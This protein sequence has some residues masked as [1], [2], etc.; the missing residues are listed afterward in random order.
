MTTIITRAGKGSA[1]TN[2]E[3]DQNFTNLNNDKPDFESGTWTPTLED[4]GNS[5]ATS[6]TAVS[7]RYVKVGSKVTVFGAF[8]PDVSLDTAGDY[9]Y[10]GGL[11]FAAKSVGGSVSNNCGTGRNGA[12]TTSLG[13]RHNFFNVGIFESASYCMIECTY[14]AAGTQL[15]SSEINFTIS[16]ETDA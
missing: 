5:G 8:A 4:A 14:V 10:I 7:S 3:G 9:I 16:Y 11:P 13:G 15:G 6:I 12:P 2:A 1:L